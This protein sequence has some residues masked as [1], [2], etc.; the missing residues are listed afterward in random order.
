MWPIARTVLVLAALS[1][2]PPSPPPPPLGDTYPSEEA[3][4]R[5]ARGRLLEESGEDAQ[6]LGEYFRGLILDDTSPT[7]PRRVSELS[8][9]LGDPNRALE[10]AKRAVALD[11]TDARGQWLQGISLMNLGRDL[12]ALRALQAAVRADSTE[13]EY[14]RALA[15]VA[16]RLDR[17]S[18]V[19]EA[20]RHTVE[21]EA[22]DA[23]SWFQLAAAEARLGRFAEAEKALGE[24]S[25]LNPIRPGLFFLDGW[26]QESLGRPERAVQLF[27]QHLD[28]HKDDQT[29][30][31]RLA[32]LLARLERWPQAYEEAQILARARPDDLEARSIEIDL[33]FRS[34]H[35][36]DAEAL[37]EQW[38]AE[39]P[40]DPNV[41][42]LALGL[43]ARNGKEAQA[44]RAVES[45][46]DRE[47]QE[48]HR[49]VVASRIH[50]V[51]G[52]PA[53]AVED[54][55]RAI[56]MA[57]DSLQPRVLLARLHQDQ[58]RPRDAEAV[59]VET[60]RLFPA[61]VGV[62]L[63]LA[64]CRERLGDLAGAEAAARDALALEPDDPQTLNFLGYLL[65]DHNR[66]V[67]EAVDLVR[68]ALEVD[69][70]N[71]A[72]LDSLGWA[73]YR[74]GRLAEARTL[75]E[76]AVV[77]TGGDSV[78]HEHLGDVYNDMRLF[79]LAKDQYRRALAADETNTRLKTKLG[80]M[81]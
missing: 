49:W 30:R 11:S 80:E 61:Q 7:F 32:N 24:A 36:R 45:W 77:R 71:G 9:R 58:D 67:E 53:L 8:A 55:R 76:R 38:R 72:Y 69:P 1:S 78:V 3:L 35:A 74:L 20:F 60:S 31:R 42:S 65:A 59:W 43:L 70:D 10:F 40:N 21:L 64:L 16:E 23:E 66:K 73:Y 68:R 39:A 33:A 12:E 62:R 15:R 6:A 52:R 48:L 46:R 63:D 13:A 29:T 19:A 28:I 34:G 22:E 50:Q 41:N 27:R 5:Y 25:R 44:V 2:P 18:I 51:A 14:H 75:L 26:V 56:A 47:P 37:I 4:I 81:R 57:P 17:V 54:L 79:D